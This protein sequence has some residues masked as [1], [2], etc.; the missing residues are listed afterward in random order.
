M[1]KGR[2]RYSLKRNRRS[3]VTIYSQEHF[4]FFCKIFVHLKVANQKLCYFQMPRSI[5]K[6]GEQ[7]NNILE[8]D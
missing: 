8:N 5:E 3:V 7:T 2:V 6:P 1:I 4:V